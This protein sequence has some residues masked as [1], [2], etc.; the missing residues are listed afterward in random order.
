MSEESKDLDLK[1]FKNDLLR[2]FV[3]FKKSNVYVALS[4]LC[5]FRA[6]GIRNRGFR[7]SRTMEGLREHR[8]KAKGI[9]A[10]MVMID[11]LEREW[12]RRLDRDAAKQPDHATR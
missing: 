8:G 10:W 4:S 3:E 9:T 2:E 11:D 12:K 1:E 5:K 6:I 7:E